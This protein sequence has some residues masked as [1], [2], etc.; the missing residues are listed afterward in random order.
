M[1]QSIGV[2][3]LALGRPYLAM[4]LLSAKS[5][6]ETNPEIPYTI[7]TNVMETPPEV[8]FFIEGVDRWIY[9]SEC[10]SNNR[11]LKTRI[12]D[13]SEYDNTVFLDCDTIV[14]GRL[15]KAQQILD[16]F[17][18]A[19]RLNRYPQKRSGKGDVSV[20]PG[21]QISDLPH[22]NSGVMLMNRSDRTRRFF[23]TWNNKFHELQ[24]PYDQV[25][26]VPT[27]FESDA[28]VLSLD[29]RWN[30]TDPG[31]GRQKWRASTIIFHY[32]TNICDALYQSILSY[33]GLVGS[34]DA[35]L[36]TI[37]FLEN[38]RLQKRKQ[39]SLFRFSVI[40]AVW[41]ITSPVSMKR[42]STGV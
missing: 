2:I 9:V 26:L 30:A 4:A 13:F 12:L 25:S 16:Y 39:C 6:R 35:N 38:K 3:Y 22:W 21:A 24:C 28:R 11:S 42:Y 37:L 15:D 10:S 34:Q 5:L 33:D 1:K 31:L 7:V 14:L 40:R 8:T 32:A 41:A 27:I 23:E 17:D 18:I 29:E 19:L 36:E 20:L